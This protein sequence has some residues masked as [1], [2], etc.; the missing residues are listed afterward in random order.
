LQFLQDLGFVGPISEGSVTHYAI[1][2]MKNQV[3]PGF[4]PELVAVGRAK[5][6]TEVSLS[7]PE[8]DLSTVEIT[9]QLKPKVPG[10]RM[11]TLPR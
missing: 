9:P 3:F 1:N 7:D 5:Q 8:V 4:L 2:L 6:L 10:S 11:G